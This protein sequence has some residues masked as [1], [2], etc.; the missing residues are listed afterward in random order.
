[1]TGTTRAR[2]PSFFSTSTAR[3]R[4]TP[5]GSRRCGLPSTSWNAWVMPG[6]CFAACTIAKPIRCVNEIFFPRATSW[7]FSSLRR[8]SSVS[9]TMSRNEVAVGTDKESV[10]FWT[11]RAAG[12][13]IGVK[14]GAG[15]REAGGVG[16][17]AVAAADSRLPPPVSRRTS[18]R[19]VGITGSSASLP[20]SKRFRHSSPTEAGSRRYCSYIT[21]TKAALWV[22]KTNSLTSSN[23]IRRQPFNQQSAVSHQL[24]PG[25]APCYRARPS[26]DWRSLGRDLFF[27]RSMPNRPDRAR[28]PA[29]TP[30]LAVA[31]VVAGLIAAYALLAR[32]RGDE[33]AAPDGRSG[34]QERAR[35]AK[36]AFRMHDLPKEQGERVRINL[37]EHGA[38]PAV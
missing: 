28:S 32:H 3:P 10:M 22:P 23:L 26:R 25:N 21:C 38:G 4:L 31:V 16:C 6:S 11:R 18:S 24:S 2:L 27:L 20:L 9:T 7:A 37:Y 5:C 34:F 17:G 33:T 29:A 1:M 14:P 35:E 19:L 36:I 30:A 15:R 8:A 12:P 13:V